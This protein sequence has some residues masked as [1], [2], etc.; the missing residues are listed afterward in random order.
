MKVLIIHNKYS[1]YG[2]EDKIVEQQYSILKQNGVDVKLYCKD[3]NSINKLS[4]T[5]KI[6]LIKD[7]YCSKQ[8]EQELLCLLDD[9]KPDIVHIHN[10]YPLVSPVVYDFFK[11]YNIPII[12]T[13]HNYRFI[14]PNGL[15]FNAN[16]ICEKCLE[17]DSFYQCFHNKCYHNSNIQ[18]LWYADIIGRAYKKGLFE[19]I[20][21]FISLNG[22]VKDKMIEKG[23]GSEKISIIPNCIM[24]S[25]GD[26]K[27]LNKEDYYLY[28]GR[29]SEEKGIITLMKT[30]S[31]LNNLNLK[32]IGDGPLKESVNK[33]VLDNNL[34]NIELLGF[35]GGQEKDELISK[36]KA[37][38]VPSEW[39]DNFP[40]VV[41]EAFSLGTLVIASSIGGLQYMIEENYNGVKFTAGNVEELKEK[42]CLL[43]K[44]NETILRLSKNAYETYKKNYTEDI[45]YN[46]H[47]NLY[48]E[49]INKRGK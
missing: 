45:Y 44:D 5:N 35:K 2:G 40:T 31:G 23:Y 9:F 24:K 46:G 37:V 3:N 17:K 1:T 6:R 34:D 49:L 12:Q 20:D 38:I 48:R 8:V 19:N 15:M 18:S 42:I 28:I 36:A 7:A 29:L 32:I 43:D 27:E 26:L 16:V 33:F 4:K 10:V 47:M 22:F 11:K 13:L 14:C 30:F 41:L 25:D 39:Y 21:K